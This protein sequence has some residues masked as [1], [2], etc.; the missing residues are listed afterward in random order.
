MSHTE[1]GDSNLNEELSVSY[2]RFCSVYFDL[3]PTRILKDQH[4][5]IMNIKEQAMQRDYRN[6]TKATCKCLG[7]DYTSCRFIKRQRTRERRPI[8]I[9]YIEYAKFP[10][11]NGV[12]VGGHT[13]DREGL[14]QGY[15]TSCTDRK[16]STKLCKVWKA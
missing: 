3:F 10:W 7:R 15:Q 12:H 8:P 16:W 14:L 1:D 5:A 2:A 6:N 13:T 4:M 9:N 11:E